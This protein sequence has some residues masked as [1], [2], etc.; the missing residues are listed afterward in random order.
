MEQLKLNVSTTKLLVK[1]LTKDLASKKKTG[2]HMK[3]VKMWNQLQPEAGSV[4]TDLLETRS[5]DP[6]TK[7][8]DNEMDLDV[9]HMRLFSLLFRK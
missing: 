1:N 7:G 3:T 2:C 9:C 5:L 6:H 4:Q 8:T